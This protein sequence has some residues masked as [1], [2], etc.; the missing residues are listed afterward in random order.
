[1]S[2]RRTWTGDEFLLLVARYAQEG[3]A[4]LAIDLGRSARSVT[5]AASRFRLKSLTRRSRQAKT[6]KLK[7]AT[8]QS[9]ATP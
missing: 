8:A 4:Q 1:M 2:T 3:P 5:S 9:Q 6:R 7:H